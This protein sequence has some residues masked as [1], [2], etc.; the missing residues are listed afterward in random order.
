M[1]EPKL[2]RPTG[3]NLPLHHPHNNGGNTNTKMLNGKINIGGKSDDYRLCQKPCRFFRRFREQTLAKVVHATECEDRTLRR[4]HIFLSVAHLITDHHTHLRCGSSLGCVA[5]WRMLKII[6][7]K[8]ASLM[9]LTHCTAY[10]WLESGDRLAIWLNQ[11]FSQEGPVEIDAVYGDKGKT[12]KHGKGKKGEDKGPGKHKGEH[13]SSPKF[14]GGK[15]RHK[16]KDC[17]YKHTVAEVGMEESVEPSNSSASSSTNRVT[18][19]PPGLFF[20]WNRAVYHS[21]DLHVEEDRAQSGWL[22]ELVV[23]SDDTIART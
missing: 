8:H 22:C 5:P 10:D 21:D 18:P 7:S 4:T 14:E 16:L 17:R 2:G 13:E 15:W 12:G 3:R 9:C 6:H 23:G 1:A 20:S 19:P 11:L